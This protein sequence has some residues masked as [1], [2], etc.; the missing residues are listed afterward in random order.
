VVAG[1]QLNQVLIDGR[2]GLN[3]LLASTLKKMGLEVTNM[4][5]PLQY[6]PWEFGYTDQLGDA[7]SYLQDQRE[8]PHG[9]CQVQGGQLRVI[10][11]CHTRLCQVE[12][13]ECLSEKVW[14]G[15]F[16]QVSDWGQKLIH[17]IGSESLY[18]WIKTS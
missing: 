5:T 16:L 18:Y 4:L 12:G 13:M 17:A 2:S 15:D 8:L 1:A 14:E 7:A 11:P 9:E 10:L 6:H 3:L